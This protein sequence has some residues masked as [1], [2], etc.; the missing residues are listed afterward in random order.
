[1]V[2]SRE[3]IQASCQR[4]IRRMEGD[5][6]ALYKE[7][8]RKK[9]LLSD[10]YQ[11]LAD[12]ILEPLDYKRVQKQYKEEVVRLEQ[13]IR[14]SAKGLTGYK[15]LVKL[16]NPYIAVLMEFGKSQEITRELLSLLVSEIVVISSRE[17]QI[18]FSFEDE[19]RSLCTVREDFLS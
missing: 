7:V 13:K 4:K 3:T 15:Q 5:L 10:S 19:F 8:T 16:E 18:V 6:Q 17:I 12:G 9:E 11:D 1:M 2:L 14:E